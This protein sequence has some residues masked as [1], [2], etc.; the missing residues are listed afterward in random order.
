MILKWVSSKMILD[1]CLNFKKISI[2]ISH[3][4][5]KSPSNLK[6]KKFNTHPKLKINVGNNQ[7]IQQYSILLIH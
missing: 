3:I 1:F 5:K 2:L 6:R 7:P 4:P